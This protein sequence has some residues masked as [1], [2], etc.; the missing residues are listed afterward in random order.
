M[1]P[2]RLSDSEVSDCIREERRYNQYLRKRRAE[3]IERNEHRSMIVQYDQMIFASDR[4]LVALYAKNRRCG[5]IS[6]F[7]G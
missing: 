7:T 4:R 1:K 6:D 2:C 3:S 5:N